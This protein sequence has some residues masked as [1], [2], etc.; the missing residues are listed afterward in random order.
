MNQTWKEADRR[1]LDA[2]GI[3][4][5]EADRQMTVLRG[6]APA[7][8]LDRPCT[9]GDGLQS[10]A[11][12]R[13]LALAD[14]GCACAAAGRTRLFIPAS[15]AATRMFRELQASRERPALMQAAGLA[16]A[17][18]EGD[19]DALVLKA[20]L[21]GFDRFAFS[22]ALSAVLAARGKD[23]GELRQHGPFGD[24]LAALLE[25]EGLDCARLPKALLLFHREGAGARTP[26]EDHL[27]DAA[28]LAADRR[29]AV[30]AHFTIPA[31]QRAGFERLL[32]RE[33]AG[34][35]ARG[36]RLEV[37][38]SEQSPATDTLAADEDGEAF[39][40]RTGQL[41]LRPS[42]H[43]ALLG[44]LERYGGDLAFI[45]NV[46]NIA[47]SPWRASARSWA[48][49]LIG[50]LEETQEEV[51]RLLIRLRDA[52]DG[53]APA[54]A[55]RFLG[56]V[57]GE[58]GETRAG[59]PDRARLARRLARPIRVCG[60]VPNTGEPGGGP[61]WVRTPGDAT[62]P[63]IVE[64]AQLGPDPAQRRIF[65]ASTHFNPVFL[66]CGLRD[67]AG[68][69]FALEAFTD[70]AAAIVTRKPSRGRELRAL[71]RPGLWNGSM[72]GWISR[73]VEVPL[74]V[75]CPVKSVLDLLR[76]EHQPR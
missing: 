52:G 17:A 28:E 58:D 50:L 66:A 59:P 19:A 55:V 74:D 35:A 20:F 44:N 11:P 30:R 42:G 40:D 25:P 7:L 1:Q 15:G 8:T 27:A 5:A 9:I 23:A 72:A 2:R 45:R 71:E 49:A 46:D 53:G 56:E 29:G 22:D 62:L 36:S 31:G 14:R 64:S 34:A 70:P 47:A 26:F 32:E 57:S 13:A 60:M 6:P 38:F 10:L 4:L 48:L 75:F 12:D 41:L 63:Q 68:E 39:R 76:A 69:P 67:A 33:A 18:A 51:G 65:E 37:T 54:A 21:E 24:L 43:G 3:S 73:F 61:V 16:S